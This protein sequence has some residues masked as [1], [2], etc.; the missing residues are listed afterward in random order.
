MNAITKTIFVALLVSTTSAHAKGIVSG[1]IGGAIGNITGKS[2][3]K[4]PKVED[5]LVN[6]ANSNNKQLPMTTSKD[7]RLDNITPGPGLRYTYYYTLVNATSQDV[8]DSN[9][10]DFLQRQFQ[11][12]KYNYCSNPQIPFFLKNG[13]TTSFSYQ[14][15]DGVLFVKFDITPKDCGYAN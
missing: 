1:L 3:V 5:V 11:S 14:L 10:M 6:M 13:V 15:S 4:S 8:D 7:I 9:R 2:L 12:A